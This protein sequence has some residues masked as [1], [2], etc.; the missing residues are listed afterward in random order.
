M[1]SKLRFSDE[2]NL[3]EIVKAFRKYVRSYSIKI[4]KDKDGNTNDSLVHLVN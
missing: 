2:L 1:P 4:I 3:V